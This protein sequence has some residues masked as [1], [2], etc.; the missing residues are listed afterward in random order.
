LRHRGLATLLLAI[1]LPSAAAAEA[2]RP[3]CADRPGKVTPAC[4]VDAGH[5]SVETALADAVFVRGSGAHEDIYTYGASELR[6]GVTRR[7]EI[8]ASWAPLIVDHLQGGPTRSGVGDASFGV[9]WSITDPD[10]QSGLA[11]SLEPVLTAPTATH[12]LGQGGWGGGLRVPLALP[13]AGG[14]SLGASPSLGVVPNADRPGSH[15]AYSV[16]VALG[17]GFGDTSL[18]AELWGLS[19]EDPSGRVRQAS[20]DLTLAQLIGKSAQFDAG[21]NLGLN[22]ATPQTEVYVG[23]SRRF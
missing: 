1:G 11:A 14:F 13:L 19:N 3:F 18:G 6:F 12:G 9:R 2:L 21:V 22:H 15:L 7:L 5:L 17:R 10:A 23:L 8:E 16:A 20:F 4:I